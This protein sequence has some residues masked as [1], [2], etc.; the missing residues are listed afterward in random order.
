LLI[1]STSGSAAAPERNAGDPLHFFEGNTLM[2]STTRVIAQKPYLTR[3]S[4]RGRIVNNRELVLVQHVD[5]VGRRQFDRYWHIRELAPGQ[6]GGTM[7]EASGPVSIEKRGENYLLR[8]ALADDV[9]V[10][11]WLLPQSDA[12]VRVR[13]TIR[14]YGIAVG[15]SQG[16]IRRV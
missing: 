10:E 3:S 15:H 11:Q 14:K 16:W 8:F 6:F 13:V 7:S 2:V 4:G 5:E 9:K 1:I 12:L